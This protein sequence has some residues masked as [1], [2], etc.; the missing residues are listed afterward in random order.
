MCVHKC[1]HARGFM[2]IPLLFV[3]K[4]KKYL[5]IQITDKVLTL[6]CWE[7]WLLISFIIDPEFPA[8]VSEWKV[9]EALQSV[10]CPHRMASKLFPRILQAP[11][12]ESF[13]LEA[14]DFSLGIIVQWPGA[15]LA[16]PLLL[17]N[18]SSGRFITSC[19]FL[20]PEISPHQQFTWP[21][22][23]LTWNTREAG[24]SQK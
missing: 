22:P 19:P 12:L 10:Q 24:L 15:P 3:L 20:L 13:F 14:D 21:L 11:S 17:L 5:A 16:N 2:S 18:H 9:P 23:A 6:S 8:Q 1:L 4:P 7:G